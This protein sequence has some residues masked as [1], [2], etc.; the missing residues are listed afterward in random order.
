MIK[1][2]YGPEAQVLE[3]YRVSP[4]PQISISTELNYANDTIIGYSY[5]ISINGVVATLNETQ[6]ESLENDEQY[7]E[8][9]PA[10][11]LLITENEL[12]LMGEEETILYE[13][14]PNSIDRL[15]SIRTILSGIENIRKLFSRNGSA[16]TIRDDQNNNLLRAKGGI[17]QSISF[18]NSQNQWTST[19]PYSIQLQ[20]NELEI[21]DESILCADSLIHTSSR[22]S[23]LVD[24]T[25]YKIKNFSDSWSFAVDEPIYN[26]IDGNSLD[27]I[28]SEI[29]ISYSLSATGKNYF[30]EDQLSPGWLQA[31]N[32]VQKRLYDQVRSLATALTRSGDTCSA[33]DNL[34]TLHTNNGNGL[35]SGITSLYGI[36][37]ETL[38]CNTSE[39]EGTFQVQYNAILK[40]N[41]EGDYCASNVKHTFNKN[42]TT[43]KNGTKNNISINIDGEVEGLCEGGLLQNFGAFSF[44]QYGTI[45]QAGSTSTKY[46]N[47]NSFLS[48]IINTTLDDLKS[49]YK[50]D[51]DI[52][53]ASLELG[54]SIS[55]C[56]EVDLEIYPSSFSITRNFMTGSISYSAQYSSDRSCTKT[57]PNGETIFKTSVTV[58]EPVPII[59]EFVIPNGQYVIQDIGTFTA[60]KITVTS[61][62]KK[63]RG[64]CDIQEDINVFLEDLLSSDMETLFPFLEFPD[65]SLFVLTNKSFSYN[66][67]EGSYTVN[68]AYIC[69]PG[70]YI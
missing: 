7:Q 9:S 37:N 1:F 18:N 28:N 53:A 65:E 46:N 12:I 49:S 2:Y 57:Q 40:R 38:S 69:T 36:Y 26:H 29:A 33:S 42:I 31:K 25:K 4:A 41:Y 67:L 6:I 56:G 61:E 14:D 58:D 13:D 34:A 27:V 16:L 50:T 54:S 15:R 17:L 47:A 39:S 19:C 24:I 48:K 23:N 59:S 45:L 43:S 64:C 35:I 10:D 44:P 68:L 11:G 63:N 22:T 60:K 21:L 66:I 30:I 70:C 62:G 20:F 51:L 52:T 55:P 3:T 32:F 5:V 8:E